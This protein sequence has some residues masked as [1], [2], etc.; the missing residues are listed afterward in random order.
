[1]SVVEVAYVAPSLMEIVPVGGVV[2]N[3]IVS[4]TRTLIF[5]AASLNIALTVWLPSAVGAK[6]FSARFGAAAAAISKVGPPVSV[7]DLEAAYGAHPCHAPFMP[8]F[9]EVSE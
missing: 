4:V 1:M 9:T 2:S 3:K 7:M 6:I 8:M 5:P